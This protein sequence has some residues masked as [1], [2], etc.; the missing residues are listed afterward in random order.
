MELITTPAGSYTPD[1]SAP[2]RDVNIDFSSR[3]MPDMI[4]LTQYDTQPIIAV[5]MYYDGAQYTVPESAAVNIRLRK[6]DGQPVYNQ[7]LG[8][9]E[10]RHTAYI[11]VTG[12]MSAADGPATAVIEVIS[13]AAIAGTARFDA[14]VERNP[15]QETDIISS[16]EYKVLVEYVS[17]AEESAKRAEAA[18]EQT[19]ADKQTTSDLADQ[20][21]ESAGAAAGSASKA[22]ESEQTAGEHATAADIAKA[23]AE[24]AALLAKSWA[25]GETDSR[26][27]EDEDNAKYYAAQALIAAIQAAEAAE[28]AQRVSQGAIGYYDTPEL[29]RERHP[30]AE[31]GNWAIVGSTDTIWVWD[32]D[33]QVWA[34]TGNKI[35][36]SQYYTRTEV[37]DLLAGLEETVTASLDT[38][39]SAA[40]SRSWDV[41]V[42]ASGWHAST[43]TWPEAGLTAKWETTIAVPG[44]VAQMNSA[45]TT[46]TGGTVAAYGQWRWLDTAADAVTLYSDN[47][48]VPTAAFTMR[49]TEVR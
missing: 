38:K 13:N 8:V 25:R 46:H 37:D 40:T 20:A 10:D 5:H 41:S 29:L 1:P 4:R 12:Q 21:A 32:S 19:A 34:N 31:D 39:V 28:D 45:M 11:Q 42:P 2:V 7:A 9:S 48:S 36:L 49:I 6:H 16:P 35:D 18:A 3:A 15:V 22:A 23:A 43:A 26:E 44:M 14:D 47:T 17:D 33:D 30:E 27:G 24:A